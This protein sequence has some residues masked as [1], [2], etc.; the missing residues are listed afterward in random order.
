MTSARPMP[1]LL[2]ADQR[3]LL[4]AMNERTAPL[5]G[6][7]LADQLAAAARR[8]GPAPALIAPGLTLSH[9]ELA[10]RVDALAA[11]LTAAGVTPGDRVAL[12]VEY[13]W[14][15][16][17]AALAVLRTGAICLPLPPTLPRPT[18]WQR[19]TSTK[20][21]AV[22]TQSWLTQRMDWPPGLQVVTV[23]E[24][25]TPEE[26]SAAEAGHGEPG[27]GV[28]AA[29]APAGGDEPGV[30]GNGRS[31]A[32]AAWLLETAI[33]HRAIATAAL[34]VNR[35]FGVGP[36]D[37]LL[38]LAPVDSPLALYELFGP[39]LAGAALVLTQDIDLRAPDVLEAVLRDRDVTVWHS[40]PALLDL[41]LD[42]LADRGRALPGSLRL[43]LLG[44]ERLDPAQIRR[45]R[46]A[47]PHGP[48]VGHLASATGSGPWT[49]CM[50][51]GEL[52][53]EWRSVPIGAPLP[54]Q[55][56]F[57]LS[58]AGKPCPVWVAGRVHYGGVA[59]ETCP[60]EQP[61]PETAAHPETGETL[62]RSGR[63][64]RLLPQGLIDVVGDETAQVMVRG[65]PLNVQDTETA[66][67]A[68][69]AVHTAVVV[70][71]GLG[72]DS[73]AWV[74]L[75]R[76]ATAG[77][78]ELLAHLR[79]K[80][81]PYLMPGRIEIVDALPL[82]PDGRVDR[83]RVAAGAPAPQSS[84]PAPPGGAA[85]PAAGAK[86]EAEL[87]AEVS[88]VTCRVLGLSAVEPDMN[89]QDAGATSIELVRLATILE[90]E[91]GIDTDIEELLRFP[92]VAVIVGKHLGGQDTPEPPPAPLTPLIQGIGARQTFKDA[93]NGI[94]HAYDDADGIPLT[95]PPDH[96]LTARRSHHAFAPRPVDLAPLADLL[97]TLREVREDGEP[98]HAYPS[99]GSAYPVQ[100]YLLVHPGRVNGLP[101]GSYYHHPARN[102]LIP[103]DPTA[104]LPATAHAEINRTAY[105]QAAFSLYLVSA[106]DAITPLYGELAWDFTVFEA[107]AMT[108]LLMRHAAGTGLGL[109]PIGSMD[110][111]PLRDVFALGDHHRFVH[112]L[113]GGH[114][115]EERP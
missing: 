88:R 51:V 41:L 75:H 11:R 45:L 49:T 91:L 57:I 19:A 48:A 77:E 95:G 106:T 42:H 72:D 105:E 17:T 31:A 80:V 9:T 2:P 15:Q 89:L 12:T 69:D 99:A 108:Q 94:R 87:L 60:G 81:S 13:G 84:A 71:V 102:R 113:L 68:H 111:A 25:G 10:A 64:A 27:T 37:R 96:D 44:G 4:R 34:E 22:L 29:T 61:A 54:N 46:E 1:T 83:A 40:P 114:P 101:G 32:D 73:L 62:L 93:R 52:A 23:D 18:R 115:R 110:P 79:R 67:A 5:P 35:S 53:P 78:D 56:V 55:R 43:L 20:A 28:T 97:G 38:A 50:E 98:R 100:T 107:G 59:A 82:T 90:E 36:G 103:I 85:T 92:S 24:P 7:T 26:A 16:L 63:F 21:R 47:A 6:G 39:L 112:A 65:R 74:R 66:L 70:P 86:G 76:G 109:C 3:E 30:P 14:E 104:T 58:E 8:H 33:S